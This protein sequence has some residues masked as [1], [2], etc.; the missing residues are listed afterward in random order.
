MPGKPLVNICFHGIGTPK[1]DLEPGEDAYWI[2]AD[3][4]LRILDEIATWPSVQISFDDGN[5]S[6]IEL[7]LPALLERELTADFFVLA[8]RL[9]TAG[10]LSSNDVRELR[11][12]GMGIG[13][14]G[15]WHRSWRGLSAARRFEEFVTARQRLAEASRTAVEIAACPL[16]RYD[17]RALNSLRT[18][19]YRRVYTS[20][21]RRARAGAWFQPRFSV[22][23]QDTPE[24]LRAEALTGPDLATR[25]RRRLAASIKRWR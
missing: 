3:Q 14:H 6:D 23:N 2:G 22:R 17:R 13:T 5:A 11:R 24:N 19:G 7:G 20:D 8:G 18:L 4:Y 10:S 1:R 9:D 15:M 25:T 21:R 16:G 12:H